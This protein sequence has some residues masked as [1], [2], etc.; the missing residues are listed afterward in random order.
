[1]EIAFGIVFK[2]ESASIL[3]LK[4]NSIGSFLK[5]SSRVFSSLRFNEKVFDK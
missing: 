4:G 2:A 5:A 3:V 1:V